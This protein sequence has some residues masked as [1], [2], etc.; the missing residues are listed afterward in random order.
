MTL[1]SSNAGVSGS[2]GVLRTFA[3][4]PRD[5]SGNFQSL[6]PFSGPEKFAAI[7]SLQGSSS[8]ALIHMSFSIQ[9]DGSQIASWS[10]TVAGIYSLSVMHG[11]NVVK[12]LPS[13]SISPGS[14]A[15]AATVV[16]GAG[17]GKVY[18]G[19]LTS[20]EIIARDSFS[21]VISDGQQ[22]F[23]FI[24][25]SNGQ[26]IASGTSEWNQQ[27]RRFVF[28]YLA[29]KTGALQVFV[30][31]VSGSDALSVPGSPFVAEGLVG[32]SCASLSTLSFLGSQMV[33]GQMLQFKVVTADDFGNPVTVGGNFF[34]IT[35]TTRSQSFT[36][37]V[38]D[39][40]DG[41]Y[42]TS[43]QLTKAEKVNV[44]AIRNGYHVSGSP[45]SS[46]VLPGA[47]S[48]PRSMINIQTPSLVAGDAFRFSVAST[49]RFGNSLSAGG[50][51]VVA[52][53]KA[54]SNGATFTVPVTD[55]VDGTYTG[56]LPLFL[57]GSYDF[58]ATLA[59][60]PIQ[61]GASFSILVTASSLDYSKSSL[62]LSLDVVTADNS[63]V[64]SLLPVDV[65]GNKASY[66]DGSLLECC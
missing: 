4:S 29:D 32:P 1:V 61:S 60:I 47:A 26:S 11:A 8:V 33:V 43:F 35:V 5:A 20:V 7:A 53:L 12:S 54:V 42:S 63:F 28:S 31:L 52:T 62:S 39:N 9:D 46:A 49:D 18:V 57:A 2:A 50:S 41:S 6:D 65:F 36:P 30:S 15:A 45:F 22:N 34:R 19:S 16:S 44:T 13:I 58:G 21:N 17:I 56:S 48:G 3:V 14:A 24:V 66:N 23:R 25:S 64:A 38:T 37:I 51:I 55:R 10:P 59:N 27:L 40:L